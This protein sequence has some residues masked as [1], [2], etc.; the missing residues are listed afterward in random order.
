[1][2][3]FGHKC[4]EATSYG[5]G[6]FSKR[7]LMSQDGKILALTDNTTF[8]LD[9]HARIVAYKKGPNT[10]LQHFISMPYHTTSCG[11]SWSIHN[12]TQDDEILDDRR[13]LQL[14]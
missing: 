14:C 6:V 11:S 2:L 13:K 9:I 10:V 8:V 4:D 3:F 5:N 7:A 1:M 12:S